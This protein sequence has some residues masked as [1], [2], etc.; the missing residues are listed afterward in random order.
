MIP[1]LLLFLFHLLLLLYRRNERPMGSMRL[2][3]PLLVF[4]L[5]A[6]FRALDASNDTEAYYQYYL[7]SADAQQAPHEYLYQVLSWTFASHGLPFS[8][9]L[10]TCYLLPFCLVLRLVRRY[11]SGGYIFHYLYFSTFFLWA[12][13]VLRQHM[14]IMLILYGLSFLLDN[15]L[16][17]FRRRCL[18]CIAV[19]VAMGF[20]HI[21]IVAFALLLVDFLPRWSR[22]ASL[23]SIPVVFVLGL[24]IRYSMD[25]FV[26]D[27]YIHYLLRH[28]HNHVLNSALALLP[29][30]ALY[31]FILYNTPR[32]YVA[33]RFVR[34]MTLSLWLMLFTIDFPLGIRVVLFTVPLLAFLFAHAYRYVSPRR[35]GVYFMMVL[36]YGLSYFT[37]E[38]ARAWPYHAAWIS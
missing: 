31:A 29:I 21:S 27:N 1:Y 22:M 4:G 2:F 16:T 12:M 5:F 35:Q 38:L 11:V 13:I 17:P 15:T 14:A 25:L 7:Q 8:L 23:L 24:L 28:G 34:A 33:S 30:I 32:E 37:Y 20:H 3:L 26:P 19:L 9:F 36:L 6:G 10:L 18:F